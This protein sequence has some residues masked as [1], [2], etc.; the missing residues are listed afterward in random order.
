MK[1]ST[2][3]MRQMQDEIENKFERIGEIVREK[4]ARKAKLLRERDQLYKMRQPLK[5]EVI[6]LVI[7]IEKLASKR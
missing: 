1:Q 7:F 2:E 6:N 4:E 3:K 5:D